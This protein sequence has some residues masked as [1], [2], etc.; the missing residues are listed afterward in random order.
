MKKKTK[1][2]EVVPDNI[3]EGDY[4]V[5]CTNKNETPDDLFYVYSADEE[6]SLGV[7]SVLDGNSVEGD[8]KSFRLAAPEEVFLILAESIL[9][10][11]KE[12]E[13]ELKRMRVEHAKILT[14]VAKR[15]KKR[16]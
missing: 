4:V 3:H 2:T 10:T 7:E 6:D 1:I 12:H 14:A 8:P 5:R 11:C 15:T 9:A 13:K 16:K